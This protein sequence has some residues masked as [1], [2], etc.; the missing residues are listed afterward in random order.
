MNHPR[1]NHWF[2]Y[3]YHN[4]IKVH[5]G[6]TVIVNLSFFFALLVLMSAPWLAVAALILSLALGYRFGI[7]KNAPHFSE[8]LDEVMRDAAKKVQTT[9]EN[10]STTATSAA[11][12]HTP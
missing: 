3:L 1:L 12:T 9:W 7:E 11:D 2:A 5:K 10:E 4:R 6:E 8:T